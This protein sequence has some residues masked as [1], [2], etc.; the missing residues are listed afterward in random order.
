MWFDVILRNG[1]VLDGAGSPWFEAD[2]GIKNGLISKIG[3]LG[4]W[5]AIRT[6]DVGGLI[7][8][9]GF[10]DIHSHSDTS[11]LMDPRM[12]SKVRQGITTEVNGNCGISPA[13][14]NEKIQ[15]FEE[16]RHIP[17]EEVDWTTMD[18]Y[19]KRLEKQGASLNVIMLVGHGTVRCYVMGDEAR[20]PTSLEMEKMKML[21]RAAME[22]GAAGLSTGL[23]Y[24]P[25]VHAHTDEIV[26]LAKV[27]A[28][29]GGIYTSHLRCSGS[30]ALGWPGEGVTLLEAVAEAIDIGRRT[31]LRIQLSHLEAQTA[32]MR[33]QD[34][35]NKVYDLIVSAREEG[36]DVAADKLTD[37]WGSVAPWP[38]RTVFPPAYLADGNEK[39][40]E[41]LRDPDTRAKIKEELKTKSQSEM[42]FVE[43]TDRLLLIRQG[44]GDSVWIFPPFNGHMKN[45]DYEYKTLDEIARMMGKNLW[46]TL[47]DLILEEEG[48]I[49]I[50][51]KQMAIGFPKEEFSWSMMMPSTDGGGIEKP[52]SLAKDRVR[53]S[54][55]GAFPTVLAWAR[56]KNT[57][58]LE[59]VVRKA[60]SLPARTIGLK[61]RGLIKEG[62]WAD[63]T[64]FDPDTVKSR[65]TF[66]NDARP[67]YP[68]G[69]P[70][71][72]VNGQIV[73]DDNE[74][75]GTLPGKVLR[76]P[77]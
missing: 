63:I 32:S 21:V 72:L 28:E 10:I 17:K 33:E 15:K 30:K 23:E 3:G 65:C 27:A 42:G 7:I 49:C 18:G 47:F 71:V 69:I 68:E 14:V 8:S 12:E 36:I 4:S 62:F 64:V 29:Y 77:L 66:E 46:D 73:V 38:R 50:S 70:Y 55:Y 6:V 22:D 39:L 24:S 16:L 60:T 41:M 34:M 54:A 19:F 35:S 48:N 51:N 1:R 76:H 75:T 45:P 53:P 13:P 9:P 5:K 20:A 52:G 40:F 59:E 11:L 26:E 37:V 74:H 67:E 43:M 56:E 44:K 57:L 61:D 2:I 25:G 31:G 58:T